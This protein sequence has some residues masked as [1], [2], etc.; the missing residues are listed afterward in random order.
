MHFD[1]APTRRSKLFRLSVRSFI[2]FLHMPCNCVVQTPLHQST[3][4]AH[5]P[6]L[7]YHC[8]HT[9]NCQTYP[10]RV[11]VHDVEV[12]TVPWDRR[13]HALDLAT[14]GIDVYPFSFMNRNRKQKTNRRQS[15]STLWSWLS[16]RYKFQCGQV[17]R[18]Q[19]KFLVPFL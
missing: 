14:S 16:L 18:F 2:V 1:L 15:H 9:R 7:F 17:L 19:L 6:L 12:D 10:E 4:S 5:Q 3:V 13:Q 8:V 11:C